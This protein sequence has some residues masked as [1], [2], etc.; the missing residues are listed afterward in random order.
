MSCPWLNEVKS[1]YDLR[2]TSLWEKFAIQF[3]WM[4]L[5]S[6]KYGHLGTEKTGMVAAVIGKF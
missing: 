1:A 5:R 6:T 3:P 4:Y 2:L